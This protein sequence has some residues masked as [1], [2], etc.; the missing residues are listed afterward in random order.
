MVN[1]SKQKSTE[2]KMLGRSKSHSTGA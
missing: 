1:I 2:Q